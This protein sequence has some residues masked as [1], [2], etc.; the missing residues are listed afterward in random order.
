MAGGQQCKQGSNRWT[1]SMSGDKRTQLCLALPMLI[2]QA[3]R[4]AAMQ[5]RRHQDN[6]SRRLN[7]ESIQM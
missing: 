2:L 5:K 1:M 7:I 4:Q 6:K 3:G